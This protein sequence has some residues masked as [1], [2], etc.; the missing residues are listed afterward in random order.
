MNIST[1]NYST[2]SDYM[3][4]VISDPKLSLTD[5]Q[6]KNVEKVL[7]SKTDKMTDEFAQAS[8]LSS[9][10]NNPYN[11]L[12]G[13]SQP[14]NPYNYSSNPRNPFYGVNEQSTNQNSTNSNLY[15]NLIAL[16]SQ[17]DNKQSTAWNKFNPLRSKL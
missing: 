14:V 3:S 17:L 15:K 6:K 10:G 11:P 5:E 8:A 7:K 9:L 16:N 1:N 13:V 2:L 4:S 12:Y